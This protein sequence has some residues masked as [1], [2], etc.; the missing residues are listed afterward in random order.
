MSY[1]NLAITNVVNV[2]VAQPPAGLANYHINNL[3]ILTKET[4]VN[5]AVTAAAPG[6]YLSPAEVLTDWGINSE[7][8]AQAL[9]IFDQLPNILDGGGSLF[10][11]PMGSG[12][13]LTVAI[14]AISAQFF[15]GGFLYAGY[16]PSN[17][18]VLLAAAQAESQRSMLFASSY[19]TADLNSPSGLFYEITAGSFRQTRGFLY[20]V[21]ALAARIAAAAYAAR[22]M[23]TDFAVSNST[24][25]MQ[26]K[27]LVGVQPDPGITQAVLTS[28][29]TVGADCYANIAG[30][31]KCFSAGANDFSDNVYNQNWFVFA[32][33][34]ALFNCI[35]TTSGKIPQTEPG[36]AVLR[37]AATQICQQAIT[38]GFVAPGTWNSAQTI[39]K[40]AVMT[41]NIENV[42]FYVY[43]SPISLQNQAA[44]TARMAPPLQV[45]IKYAGAVHSVNCIVY[46]NP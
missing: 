28:C 27:D 21:S 6:I 46:V 7:A 34:V 31:P 11:Y 44:R 12:D 43:S 33:E 17:A 23:S 41:A 25:T 24:A 32:L 16:T 45:A 30:L 13:T 38:N 8:Y 18:E 39:G 29:A 19:L 10:V 26:M 20:T 3:C 40:P 14:A 22:L 42:G 37:D 15:I 4:P 1:N 5:G 2:Q 35:A 9:A 36:M